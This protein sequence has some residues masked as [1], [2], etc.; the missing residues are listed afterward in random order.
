MTLE[1]QVSRVGHKLSNRI[2]LWARKRSSDEIYNVIDVTDGVATLRGEYDAKYIS[3]IKLEILYT[4][5]LVF[6]E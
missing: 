1:Q 2:T 3:P 4:D 5:F 6:Y